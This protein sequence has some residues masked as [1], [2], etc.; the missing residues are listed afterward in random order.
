MAL[1]LLIK[2]RKT[3]YGLIGLMALALTA[4]CGGGRSEEEEGSR[5]DDARHLYESIMKLTKIYSDSIRMAPDSATVVG[6]FER[7]NARLDT[8]NFSVAPDTDLLLTEGENDTLYNNLIA[9]RQIYDRKLAELGMAP[10]IVTDEL[11]QEN[12]TGDVDQ[13]VQNGDKTTEEKTKAQKE[14]EKAKAEKEKEKAKAQAEKEKAKAQAEKE[15]AKAQAEKEKAK[16]KAE[17]EK[18]EKKNP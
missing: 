9:L 5:P 13:P 14:K 18:K 4:G 7:F 15:K 3:A 10:R 11:F 6:A 17:K 12:E 8:I 1:H 16:A 2:M